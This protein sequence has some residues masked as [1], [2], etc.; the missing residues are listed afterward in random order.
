MD[1]LVKTISWRTTP[2]S[3][4]GERLFNFREV[5]YEI[6]NSDLTDGIIVDLGMP[7]IHKNVFYNCRVICFNREI[8][9]I[10][11]KMFMADDGNYRESR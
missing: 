11:P 3:I 5:L 6:L 8:M 10:R 4:A 7:V 2:S 1:T 9:L